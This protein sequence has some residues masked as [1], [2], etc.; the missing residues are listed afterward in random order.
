MT[1]HHF[2]APTAC[3]WAYNGTA[4]RLIYDSFMQY[5][6]CHLLRQNVH[7]APL[8]CSAISIADIL[9]EVINNIKLLIL[10]YIILDVL[11]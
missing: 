2:L 3:Q 6:I 8:H 4:F 9:Y 10:S 7:M 11:E 5:V 1:C